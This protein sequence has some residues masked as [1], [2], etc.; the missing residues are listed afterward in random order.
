MFVELSLQEFTQRIADAKPTP[1]GGSAAAMTGAMGA[2]LV[3]M[4]CNV[5]ASR[6]K[7]VDVKEEM[8][9]QAAYAETWRGRLV[10]LVD[11]DSAAFEMILTANRMPKETEEEK[12]ARKEANAAATLEATRVPLETASACVAVIERI[13]PLAAKGNPNAL[14]D[15]KVGMELVY[16]AFSGAM[17]NVQINL[18][19]LED[20]AQAEEI[21]AEILEL[22]VRAEKALNA[23][24]EE[25]SKLQ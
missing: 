15:L 20:K 8:E 13:P 14:S 1:G 11:K 10:E 16:A 2:A 4:F 3:S 24:R 23:G 19:W 12:Q 6:K 5:T 17:A 7:Y 9:Q 21:S 22:A 18:P 25:I